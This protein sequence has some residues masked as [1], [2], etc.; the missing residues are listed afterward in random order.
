M[1]EKSTKNLMLKKM[2]YDQRK[3]HADEISRYQKL[4][5]EH[6]TITEKQNRTNNRAIKFIMSINIMILVLLLIATI[7]A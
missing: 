4:L 3:K 1:C 2:L 5:Q 7:V 6:D